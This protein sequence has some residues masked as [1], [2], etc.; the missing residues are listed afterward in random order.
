MLLALLVFMTLEQR[1]F[2]PY[3]HLVICRTVLIVTSGSRHLYVMRRN[4][5]CCCTGYNAQ[6]R[7]PHPLPKK[8]IWLKMAMVAGL[9]KTGF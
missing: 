3:G 6:N 7:L 1:Q 5:E 8:M 9:R 2:L 4:F